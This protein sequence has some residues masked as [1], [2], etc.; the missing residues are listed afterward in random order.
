AGPRSTPTIDGKR[1]YA[2]GPHGDL[3]CLDAKTGTPRWQKD[4]KADFGG[5]MMSHWGFSESPLVDGDRLICTPGG[6]GAAFV[7]LDKATGNEIWRSQLPALGEKGKD[8]A[9]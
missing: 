2:I 5:L 9:A 6:K 3:L 4:F 8:G 7:A 1:L